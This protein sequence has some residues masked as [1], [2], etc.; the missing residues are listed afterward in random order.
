ML[1]DDR[2]VRQYSESFRLKV[3]SEISKGK[4]TKSEIIQIYGIS[5]E[6]LSI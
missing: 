1:K 4:Y 3:L 5:P 2:T 6:R